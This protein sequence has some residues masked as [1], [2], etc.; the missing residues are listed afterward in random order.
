MGAVRG[1][2]RGAVLDVAGLGASGVGA[3]SGRCW[4]SLRFDIASYWINSY[5]GG[6]LAALG[7]A[8]VLGAYPRFL[9]KPSVSPVTGVGAG[10][11]RDWLHAAVRRAGRFRARGGGIGHRLSKEAPGLLD[12]RSR[13]GPGIG[14][15]GSFAG[16]LESR[17]R[18]C[19]ANTLRGQ[20][21][22][23]RLALGLP[24]FHAR[25]VKLRHVELQRYY[26]YE[27]E[28]HDAEFDSLLGELKNSTHQGSDLLEVLFWT[29]AVDSVGDAAGSLAEP[30]IAFPV[31]DSRMH[32]AF[33][34][35]A[36]RQFAALRRAGC[37]LFSGVAGGMHAPA[38]IAF[39]ATA[40]PSDC[41]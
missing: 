13:G 36:V 20:P 25:D 1:H 41:S 12:V 23:L 31:S 34:V 6:C 16:L 28:A 33:G 8:L 37:G 2:V 18:R 26:D 7:G 3:C 5:Y 9:K 10:S 38:A 35:D 39:G 19:V 22:C 30:A 21:G 15:G 17:Y 14:G 40:A 27:R 4:P 29:G 11:D 24:W 32:A